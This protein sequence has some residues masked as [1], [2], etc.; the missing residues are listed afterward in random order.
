MQTEQGLCHDP[1]EAP[2][3]DCHDL[4]YLMKETIDGDVSKCETHVCNGD[5]CTQMKTTDPDN[6]HTDDDGLHDILH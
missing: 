1:A 2:P 3:Q 5:L 4:K 6:C